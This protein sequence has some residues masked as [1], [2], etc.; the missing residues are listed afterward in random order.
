[1]LNTRLLSHPI[2]WLTLW[3]MALVAFFLGH[4]LICYFYGVHPGSASQQLNSS[5]GIGVAGP[6]TAD[7]TASATNN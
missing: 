5:G 4:L 2:N 3:S 6:G 1:M 7:T